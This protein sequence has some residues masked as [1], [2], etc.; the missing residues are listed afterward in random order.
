MASGLAAAQNQQSHNY[1][2]HSPGAYLLDH[3]LVQLGDL[4]MDGRGI[5]AGVGLAPGVGQALLLGLD[6]EQQSG[7]PAD[8]GGHAQTRL[9]ALQHC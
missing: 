7:P 5:L 6:V 4:F 1:A 2:S 8:R 3:L 9:A